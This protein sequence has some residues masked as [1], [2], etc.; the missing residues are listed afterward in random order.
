MEMVFTLP[1]LALWD[2]FDFHFRYFFRGVLRD[3]KLFVSFGFAV[4]GTYVHGQGLNLI[5]SVII[6]VL[7]EHVI[8]RGRGFSLNFVAS[9][10]PG[11][12]ANRLGQS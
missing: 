3:E 4:L 10:Q 9:E 2:S 12:S 6:L 1:F 11:G 8:R 7:S 5:W